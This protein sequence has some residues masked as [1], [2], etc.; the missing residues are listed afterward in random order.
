[1]P[2]LL[3]TSALASAGDAAAPLWVTHAGPVPG[4]GKFGDT[5]LLPAGLSVLHKNL[6]LTNAAKIPVAL[7]EEQGKKDGIAFLSPN[8]SHS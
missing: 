4:V 3:L 2:W 1:M 7:D 5:Q 6:C 8:L